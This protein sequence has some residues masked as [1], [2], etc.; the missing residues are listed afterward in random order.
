MTFIPKFSSPLTA[1]HCTFSSVP[2]NLHIVIS[3]F[4]IL[5][6]TE[7]F[8]LVSSEPWSLSN[9][10]FLCIPNVVNF[11]TSAIFSSVVEDMGNQCE[12]APMVFQYI[13]MSQQRLWV[14]CRS[15]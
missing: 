4:D 11:R 3:S 13:P 9:T 1:N 15:S 6:C 5:P 8:E 14:N 12:Y 7:S 2:P 10:T